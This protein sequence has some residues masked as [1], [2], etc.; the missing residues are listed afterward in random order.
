MIRN[1]TNVELAMESAEIENPNNE[2]H[3]MQR[4]GHRCKKITGNTVDPHRRWSGDWYGGCK[5]LL[6][7]DSPKAAIESSPACFINNK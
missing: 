6:F 7:G 4:G 1:S 2:V 3:R 5:L